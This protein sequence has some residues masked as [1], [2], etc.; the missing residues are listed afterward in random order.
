MK[1][2]FIFSNNKYLRNHKMN[3]NNLNNK[4]INVCD[5]DKFAHLYD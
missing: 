5:E 1:K 2:L 3:T 4:I